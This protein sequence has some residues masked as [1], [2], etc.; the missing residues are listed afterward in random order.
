MEIYERMN[1]LRKERGVTWTYLNE[2]V[3][4]SYHGRMTDFKNGKTTLSIAQLEAVAEILSTSTDYLLGKTDDPTPA[5]QKEKPASGEADGLSE[6]ELE[7]IRL[8]G[9]ASLETQA[10]AL[11]MLRAAE[12]AR[13]TPDDE[14]G[15]K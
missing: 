8:Y 12:A 11:G 5:G 14:R 6:E 7:L 9:R 10:A 4:G 15:D 13:A 1:L 2:K 3:E